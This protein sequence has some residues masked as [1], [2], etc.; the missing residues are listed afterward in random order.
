MKIGVDVSQLAYRNTGVAN[1]LEGLLYEMVKSEHEFVLFFSSL[2]RPVPGSLTAFLKR[3]NVKLVAKKFPPTL[4][5]L[6]WNRWHRVPIESFI[7]NVDLFITSDWSEPPVKSA[8]KATI[9]Y[10]LIVYKYPNETDK[11][12]VD[13]QKKKLGWVKNESDIIFCISES[14][15]NDVIEIL[16]ISESKIKVIYPGLTS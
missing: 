7:G 11:K 8:K 2:R 6:L 15:K 13:V 14:T 5:H 1:Y 4:L 16:G 10:D 9:I 3:P 12:I